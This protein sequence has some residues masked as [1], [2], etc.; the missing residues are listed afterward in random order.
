[1][2]R[3][4][5]GSARPQSFAKA[6]QTPEGQKRAS[7][8]SH[9]RKKKGGVLDEEDTPLTP[10]KARERDQKGGQCLLARSAD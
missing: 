9:R 2:I 7:R 4:V 3:G 6:W 1:M 8:I 5:S 10:Y